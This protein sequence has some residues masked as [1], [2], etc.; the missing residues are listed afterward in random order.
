MKHVRFVH[1]DLIFLNTKL[2]GGGAS[3]ARKENKT[4]GFEPTRIFKIFKINIKYTENL[5]LVVKS[6]KQINL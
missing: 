3:F 1:V 6:R 5:I 2:G 4:E